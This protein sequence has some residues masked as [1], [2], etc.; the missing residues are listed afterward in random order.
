[1]S[2][3]LRTMDTTIHRIKYLK[4]SASRARDLA[5]QLQHM[6]D[7]ETKTLQKQC[8]HAHFNATVNNDGHNYGYTYR[9]QVCT[10]FSAVLPESATVS[11]PRVP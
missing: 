1:M 4:E 3:Q 10:V 11:Y 7:V 2:E 9:C 8:P 6:C 5:N